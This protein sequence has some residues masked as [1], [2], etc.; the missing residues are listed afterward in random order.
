MNGRQIAPLLFS[1]LGDD[2]NLQFVHHQAD[3]LTY[4]NKTFK[5]VKYTALLEKYLIF[6]Q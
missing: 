5:K 4:K 2:S 1:C 6:F 3:N